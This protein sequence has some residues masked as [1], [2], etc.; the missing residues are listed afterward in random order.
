MGSKVL[1]LDIDGT[2]VDFRGKM[3]ESA[4][5]A[6]ELARERGHK[7]VLC[8]GRTRTQLFSWLLAYGFGGLITG[9]GAQVEAD[10]KLISRHLMEQK[11]L[12]RAVDYFERIRAPY[13]LQAVNGIYAPRWCLECR[14]EVF[15]GRI[16]EKEREKQFGT[17]TRD[18]R[19]GKRVDVEKI[20]YYQSAEGVEQVR[21]GLGSYFAVEASSYQLINSSDG[22]VT[23]RGINKAYGMQRYLEY[24]GIAQEDTC[25]FGD[26]PNDREMLEFAGIGVA[27]GNAGEELKGCADF[28]AAPIDQDGLYRAFETLGVL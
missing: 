28:V 23:I 5:R 2:L 11:K 15:R 27:M 3:P 9:A 26:G 8:T 20:A 24:A 19:P 1:F 17:V 7:L 22:E 25:A 16:T 10:G 18:D 12:E 21:E 14:M 6:L 4:G 13:Y